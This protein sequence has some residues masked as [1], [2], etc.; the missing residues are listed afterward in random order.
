MAPPNQ[1]AR[2]NYNGPQELEAPAAHPHLN[3]PNLFEAAEEVVDFL[4]RLL[5]AVSI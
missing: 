5:V 3:F 1:P 2:K 4:L